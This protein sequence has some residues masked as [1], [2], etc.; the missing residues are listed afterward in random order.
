MSLQ[1]PGRAGADINMAERQPLPIP[2][3][4]HGSPEGSRGIP[5]TINERANPPPENRAHPTLPQKSG[6]NCAVEQMRDLYTRPG[7]V[8]LPLGGAGEGSPTLPSRSPTIV[9]SAQSLDNF[10]EE[11]KRADINQPPHEEGK[12]P[13]KVSQPHNETKRQLPNPIAR[14]MRK[15]AQREG[16][17]PQVLIQELTLKLQQMLADHD[18]R[19]A[20]KLQRLFDIPPDPS[21]PSPDKLQR[22]FDLPSTEEPTSDDKR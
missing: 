13:P 15:A 10:L 21:S 16:V 4:Q 11:P 20:D 14:S 2:H 9:F 22:L 19:E 17:D 1:V 8:F 6:L 18:P 12:D 5:P 7:W 3:P